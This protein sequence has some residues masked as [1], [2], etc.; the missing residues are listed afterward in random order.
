MYT[1]IHADSWNTYAVTLIQP[2]LT[3][4]NHQIACLLSDST[5]IYDSTFTNEITNN[6]YQSVVGVGGEQGSYA[7]S[8]N[9]FPTSTSADIQ[10]CSLLVYL[11]VTLA[12]FPN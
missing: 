4:Q 8:A 10:A 3:Y 5:T 7:I 1:P 9:V 2:S 12:V 6:N 11:T